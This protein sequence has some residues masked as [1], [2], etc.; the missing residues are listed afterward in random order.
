MVEAEVAEDIAVEPTAWPPL[1]CPTPMSPKSRPSSRLGQ[2]AAGSPA[3][4]LRRRGGSAA[5]PSAAIF[6]LDARDSPRCQGSLRESSLARA[7]DALGVELHSMDREDAPV[8]AMAL[9][10]NMDTAQRPRLQTA[11]RITKTIRRSAS[12]SGLASLGLAKE[13]GPPKSGMEK[14]ASAGGLPALA[15]LVPSGKRRQLP[16]VDVKTRLGEPIP[17]VVPG[18]GAPGSLSRCKHWGL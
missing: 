5:Q 4:V 15:P 13:R 16:K 10:L 2:A 11:V 1:S 8:S 9:D 6:R 14:S 7:Y 3:R 18:S 17:F 12:H